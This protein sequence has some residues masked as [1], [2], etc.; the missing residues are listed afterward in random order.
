MLRYRLVIGPVLIAALV[1]LLWL[2]QWLGPVTLPTLSL[3]ALLDPLGVD[4]QRRWVLPLPAL[5][6][7]AELPAG[8]VMLV[9]LIGVIGLA[10]HEL[11]RLLAAKGVTVNGHLL[12]FGAAVGLLLMYLAP[13]YGAVQPQLAWFGTW[14]VVVLVASLRGQFLSQRSEGALMVAGGA[15]LALV[16]LGT[17]GGFFLALRQWHSAWVVAAVILVTKA[18]DIGAYFAGKKL[19]R[20][21]LIPWLSPGK[22]CEG[23]VGGLIASGAVGVGAVALGRAVENPL[24]MELSWAYAAVTGVIFGAIGQVGDLMVSLF[25]RDAGLKDSGQ[26]LPGFGGMLDVMDSPL[27]V[28]PV[29]YW[30][31]LPMAGG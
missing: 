8:L 7:R 6:G 23:L 13:G 9:T 18:C 24:A 30:L 4:T 25:K 5:A 19:G 29:A 26:F 20:R 22:T 3:N 2:D 31:L 10:A 15:L 16:Y 11:A 1:G 17:L 27:L 14:L 21:K 28:A 12:W